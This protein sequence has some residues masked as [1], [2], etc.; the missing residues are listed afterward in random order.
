MSTLR[1]VAWMG[2]VAAGLSVVGACG[3][4]FSAGPADA[5]GDGTTVDGTGPDGSGGEAGDDGGPS[6]DTGGG[7]MSDG[8]GGG[9]IVYVSVA[10]GSD[11]ATGLDPAHPKKTVTSALVEAKTLSGLPEVH[12]CKGTY[13]EDQVAVDFDV[14]LKGAY[15][16]TTWTRTTTYGYPKFDGVDTTLLATPDVM[17]Q[18]AALVVTGAVTSATVI[19]GF[20]IA[21]AGAATSHT[22]GVHVTGSA[23]PVLT[24]DVIGGGGGQATNTNAGTGSTGVLVDLQAAPKIEECI[25]SGGNGTGP[26]G[27]AGVELDTTGAVTLASA[28]VTGG[29]GATTA[30]SGIATIGVDVRASIANP[31]TELF[32]GGTD[33]AGTEGQS[34]GVRVSGSGVSAVVAGCAIEGG[35]G[36]AVTSSTGVL[37]DAA[38]GTVVLTGDRIYGGARPPGMGSVTLGVLVSAAGSFTIAN[39]LVHAGTLAP[40]TGSY[41]VGVDLYAVAAPVIALT[42]IYTGGGAGTDVALN[43][44]VTGAVIRDDLLL[45]SDVSGGSIGVVTSACGG[46][47]GSL[48]HTGFGNLAVLYECLNGASVQTSDTTLAGMLIDLGSA[49]SNNVNVQSGCI[50]GDTSCARFAGCPGTPPACLPGI[51]GSSWSTDDGVSALFG[52]SSPDGGVPV[53]GWTAG[54]VKVAGVTTDV[55]GATRSATT[56]T[57]GGVEYTLATPCSKN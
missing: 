30:P 43:A 46:F 41:T 28:I 24:N 16:C 42:T 8:S 51:F 20:S 15:D 37:V 5:G 49:E 45:G 2:I 6:G 14:A 50:V 53:Q 4:S 54:G 9:T 48:D 32:V 47:I 27:S 25:I 39:S 34:V 22:D 13:T 10:T 55:Y 44:G 17:L 18:E 35:L 12:V 38:G 3:S 11:L 57:M 31:L 19:D 26:V 29:L 52:S 7:G 40:A 36:L 1:F 23:S 56:P 21:G 33:Q